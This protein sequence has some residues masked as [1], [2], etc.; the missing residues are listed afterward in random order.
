MRLFHSLHRH[1]CTRDRVVLASIEKGFSLIAS[2]GERG[3]ALLA[4]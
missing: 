2:V 4:D 3:L 1:K